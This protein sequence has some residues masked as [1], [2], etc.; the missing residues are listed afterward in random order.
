MIPV[1]SLEKASVVYP[2]GSSTVTALDA[3]DLEVRS[4][5]LLALVGESGSGKSTLLSVAGALQTPTSGTVM[6][7]G[8]DIQTLDD[9]GRAKLRREKIGFVFQQANLL[10]SLNARE[11]LLVTDHVRGIRGSKLRARYDRADEL[12]ARVGLEGK[13]NR[14]IAQLS[15][16][17]RQRVNI[18]RALMGNPALLLAD[19]P[20]SALDRRMSVEIVSLLSEITKE[21]DVATVMVTHDLSQLSY[22][23]NVVELIDGARKD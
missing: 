19:E 9:A 14:K 20:T 21:F 15:G 18:A 6:V 17:Q 12:L 10:G 22:A 4:G 11:Q 5:E 2:D 7:A 1:L 16:G 23:D 13:E 8:Q 3:V